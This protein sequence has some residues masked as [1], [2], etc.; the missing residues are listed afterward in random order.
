MPCSAV[1]LTKNLPLQKLDAQRNTLRRR[2]LLQNHSATGFI[3]LRMSA[4]S[5][6]VVHRRGG[7]WQI[8]LLQL[9]SVIV[10]VAPPALYSGIP[11]KLSPGRTCQ[12]L[13]FSDPTYLS[14]WP[15]SV[16]RA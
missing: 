7:S 5:D 1:C 12:K 6:A 3:S 15:C 10:F 16:E 11:Y 13:Y 9:D 8:L 4:G 14:S 2:Q